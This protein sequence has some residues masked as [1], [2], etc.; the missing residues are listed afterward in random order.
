MVKGIPEEDLLDSGLKLF[1]RGLV[2]TRLGVGGHVWHKEEV[3]RLKHEMVEAHLKQANEANSF[4]GDRP[5]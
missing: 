3:A 5:V 4:Y 2:L 1:C